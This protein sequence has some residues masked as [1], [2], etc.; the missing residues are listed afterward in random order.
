MLLVVL[1][2][3]S[4]CEDNNCV[5]KECITYDPTTS[6]SSGSDGAD[7]DAA[8]ETGNVPTSDG[9]SESSSSSTGID[10]GQCQGTD[11][12]GAQFCVAPYADNVRG[13]FA[14]VDACVGPVEETKWCFDDAACCDPAAHC[15]IR[16]YCEVEGATTTGGSDST[17]DDGGSSSTG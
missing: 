5:D 11:E 2:G 17:S 9:G 4:R 8:T 15:T 1:S 16:G 6:T 7:G 12:C 13:A 3:C 14:C 10:D